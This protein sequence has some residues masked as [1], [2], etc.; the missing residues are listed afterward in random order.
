MNHFSFPLFWQPTVSTLT[1]LPRSYSMLSCHHNVQFPFHLTLLCRAKHT[2]DQVVALVA[3]TPLLVYSSIS[4]NR[5]LDSR[6]THT[7]THTYIQQIR[8][9]S[10][11]FC[12][13]GAVFSL[14]PAVSPRRRKASLT[15]RNASSS[16][17]STLGHTLY[18]NLD[19]HWRRYGR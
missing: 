4:Q 16:Y 6:S 3:T 14:L 13:P 12:L 11:L 8:I 7:R 10:G 9:R 15:S 17:A 1:L 2:W 18:P 19:H 5:L